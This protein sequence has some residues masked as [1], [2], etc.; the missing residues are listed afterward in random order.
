LLTIMTDIN[1]YDIQALIDN[2]LDWEDE[3]SIRAAIK[4]DATY[5]KRYEELKSQKTLLQNWW[6]K[7]T[8]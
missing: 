2:E 8:N 1:D 4:E 3:K 7:K 6:K 5:T